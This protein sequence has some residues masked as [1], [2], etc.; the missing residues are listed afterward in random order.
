[1]HSPAGHAEQ[2]PSRLFEAVVHS[3]QALPAE[4]RRTVAAVGITGQMHGVVLADASG[5]PVSPLITWQDLRCGQA[6]FL[7]ELQQRTGYTLN[8]GFGCATLA[9]I[10]AQGQ[11][12]KS[13]K[14]SG[15]IGDWLV[16]QLCG[17]SRCVTDPTNA[18]SWGLFDLAA[19]R[20]EEGSSCD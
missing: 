2:D 20:W 16:A 4:I 13:A 6:G 14:T 1:M 12:L 15:T 19:L 5:H 11:L 18:A 10:A 7:R 3:V 17:R 8:S 9:H